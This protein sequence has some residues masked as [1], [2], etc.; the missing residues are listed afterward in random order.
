MVP[1]SDGAEV[2]YKDKGWLSEPLFIRHR[3]VKF[4]ADPIWQF[5]FDLRNRDESEA[6]A[7][8]HLGF[9]DDADFEVSVKA[10]RTGYWHIFSTIILR[11]D[12]KTAGFG[13]L[14]AAR[15]GPIEVSLRVGEVEYWILPADELP[16]YVVAEIDPKF[17][18]DID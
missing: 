14:V 2:S 9:F 8:L 1:V 15:S 7:T 16:Y 18:P 11:R 3:Y 5:L 12:G 17:L 4:D 13:R 10:A 6:A